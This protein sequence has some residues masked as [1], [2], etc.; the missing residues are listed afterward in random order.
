MLATVL[1]AVFLLVVAAVPLWWLLR[2]NL[3]STGDR[4]SITCWLKLVER[5]GNL[6][7]R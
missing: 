4:A 5:L 1:F 3:M 6:L 2:R 7:V